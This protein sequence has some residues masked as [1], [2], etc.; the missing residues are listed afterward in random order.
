M[1]I[2]KVGPDDLK[3]EAIKLGMKTLMEDVV[4]KFQQGLTTPEEVFALSRSD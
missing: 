4:T 2:T 1:I 3:T